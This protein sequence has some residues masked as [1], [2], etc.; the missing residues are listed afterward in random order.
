MCS[1]CSLDWKSLCQLLNSCFWRAVVGRVEIVALIA[2]VA[3]TYEFDVLV[4]EKLWLANLHP[5]NLSQ[6]LKRHLFSIKFPPCSSAFRSVYFWPPNQPNY[7]L[8]FS[9]NA[10][11]RKQQQTRGRCAFWFGA[12]RSTSWFRSR[13]LR[14]LKDHS[15]NIWTAEW[16][17]KIARKQIPVII[18]FHSARFSSPSAHRTL[19]SPWWK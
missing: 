19:T 3:Y 5:S 4:I 18:N 1:I 6:S 16:V 11:R 12:L 13:H 17:S 10:L 15:A 14:R 9:D 8:L 7:F 2:K